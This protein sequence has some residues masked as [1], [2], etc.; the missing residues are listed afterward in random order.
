MRPP[1][2]SGAVPP[3]W[4]RCCAL[5]APISRCRNG[6]RSDP[7]SDVCGIPPAELPLVFDRFYRGGGSRGRGSGGAG[8]GL[9]IARRVV[10]LHDDTIGVNS[11]GV[12]GTDC[13]FRP[14]LRS[15]ASARAH[16]ARTARARRAGGLSIARARERDDAAVHPRGSR[17][18]L[19]AQRRD[20]TPARQF[21]AAT[22]H[23]RAIEAVRAA[24][25]GCLV[26]I[27]PMQ[28]QPGDQIDTVVEGGAVARGKGMQGQ[29][30][31]LDGNG[32][33]LKHWRRSPASAAETVRLRSRLRRR[34]RAA[35]TQADASRSSGRRRR[36]A[37]KP[38]GSAAVAAR[39]LRTCPG[40]HGARS[41]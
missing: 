8:L 4:T 38:A 16:R 20:D 39:R 40:A 1:A 37:S 22:P 18:S 33:T 34:P 17:R 35:A 19:E 26:D 36:P 6:L 41:P 5:S 3:E 21:A 31:F 28:A 15:A 25:G 14:P 29:G 9:A 13:T 27:Y 23:S 30:R 24:R 11:D 32:M 2:R 7:R 12:S 10:E